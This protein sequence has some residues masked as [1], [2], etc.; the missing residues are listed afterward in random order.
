MTR[1]ASANAAARRDVNAA[2]GRAS[3]SGKHVLV[4]F[5]ASWCR[6]SAALERLF[7]HALVAPLLAAGFEV[8]RLDV[9]NRDRHLDLA[10]TWGVDYAAGIPAVA[11]LDGDGELV[12]AT[13][14]GELAS[15]TTLTPMALVTL[16]HP[17][18][19]ESVRGTGS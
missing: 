1:G 19:P 9:G 14:A 16:L 6:D 11:V 15:A 8:V 13:R 10:E 12:G 3:E 4:V 7:E 17:W 18:L 5:H 2:T